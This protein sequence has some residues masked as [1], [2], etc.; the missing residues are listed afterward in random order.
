MIVFSRGRITI[1]SH[2]LAVV[3][4]SAVANIVCVSLIFIQQTAMGQK[5]KI[6]LSDNTTRALS[7]WH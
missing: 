5:F 2:H 4:S 6:E 1:Q 3:M 7:E